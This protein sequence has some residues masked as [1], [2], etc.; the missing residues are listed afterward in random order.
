MK[1]KKLGI[2]SAILAS[3]CCLGPLILVLIGLGSLG[4]GAVISRYHWWFLG[5]G[6]F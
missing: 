1:A 3:I 4:I 6:I 5:G 2:F